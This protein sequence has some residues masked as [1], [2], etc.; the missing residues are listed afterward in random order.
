[1]I[2]IVINYKKQGLPCICYCLVRFASNGKGQRMEPTRWKL[3]F[4]PH[5]Y[6]DK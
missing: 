3:N 4:T 5:L 2:M 1:M 6:D